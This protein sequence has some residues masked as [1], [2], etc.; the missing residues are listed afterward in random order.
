MSTMRFGE[1]LVK[2]GLVSASDIKACLRKQ[3]NIKRSNYRFTQLGNVLLQDNYIS[4]EQMCS[5]VEDFKVEVPSNLDFDK[6]HTYIPIGNLSITPDLVEKVKKIEFN[7]MFNAGVI[8]IK[9][10]ATNE[11]VSF[12]AIKLDSRV[13]VFINRFKQIHSLHRYTTKIYRV[14]EI[15]F[16]EFI[17]RLGDSLGIAKDSINL[18]IYEVT[19]KDQLRGI[20]RDATK[21]NTSDIFIIPMKDR[22]IIKF[23]VGTIGVIH[24]PNFASAE[25]AEKIANVIVQECG[26]PPQALNEGVYDG[27]I[28]SLFGELDRS[29]SARVNVARTINGFKVVMRLIP[30][31]QKILS[32]A[33]LGMPPD[34]ENYVAEM[35]RKEAGLVLITGHMGSGKNT[36]A[37]A[38]LTAMDHIAR[39][40]TTVEQPVERRL[41]GIS[42]I[43]VSG[44]MDFNKVSSAMVRQAID[45]LFISEI[46]DRSTIDLAVEASVAGMLVM[47]TL[48]IDRVAQVWS[49]AHALNPEIVSRFIIALQGVMTQKLV[50]KICPKCKEEIHFEDLDV[51][52]Q[53]YL[54]KAEFYKT[55]S[56]T[57]KLI[58]H[59]YTGKLYH[60]KGCPFCKET[61]YKGL[62]VVTEFLPLTNSLKRALGAIESA[63]ELENY[64]DEYMEKQRLS[65]KYQGAK[66]LNQGIISLDEIKR[67]NIFDFNLE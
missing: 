24:N 21:Q 61:G 6:Q 45:V 65:F 10:D 5:A 63:V 42:Q 30:N 32:I 38:I 51:D 41:P 1:F 11:E 54:K 25:D 8:P 66:M 33:E 12:V 17:K 28:E 64:T 56:K 3:E 7:S 14:L 53:L 27:S 4:E 29:W 31:Q 2:Q 60:G 46:R 48:H 26:A 55:D 16:C 37:Y 43:E 35:S 47:S 20:Y 34:V 50:R 44:N 13:E 15:P 67:K 23:K 59:S 22:V 49:R 62:T 39:E 9:V 57:G 18:G 58:P 36:T 52:S 40:I 19:L